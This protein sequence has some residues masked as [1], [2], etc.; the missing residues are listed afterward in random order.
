[1]VK[2]NG[3]MYEQDPVCGG[4]VLVRLTA[5]FIKCQPTE[6]SCHRLH[7][8][9]KHQCDKKFACSVVGSIYIHLYGICSGY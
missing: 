8:L 2:R 3:L 4:V 7:L 6:T 1:M 9:G 5:N